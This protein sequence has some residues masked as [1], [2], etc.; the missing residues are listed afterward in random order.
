[1]SQLWKL[2]LRPRHVTSLRTQSCSEPILI[3]ISIYQYWL[4]SI[5]SIAIDYSWLLSTFIDYSS[6]GKYKHWDGIFLGRRK[7]N[8]QE[9]KSRYVQED[10]VNTEYMLCNQISVSVFLGNVAYL[11]YS[12]RLF[13]C[14][15]WR[16]VVFTE[17]ACKYMRC[18]NARI[19][20]TYS[21]PN[22]V[23]NFN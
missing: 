8:K 15:N 23:T 10:G 2:F 16:I 5:T 17:G 7:A 1:M 22:F 20:P 21:N 19:R 18:A 4:L 3:V 6:C 14:E 11:G 12:I 9:I 13:Y